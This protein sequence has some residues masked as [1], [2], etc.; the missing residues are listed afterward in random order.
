VRDGVNRL[1]VNL[2]GVS[3]LSVRIF[4]EQE[5][6]PTI[7]GGI[8]ELRIPGV[9]ATEALRPPVIAERALRG[10]RAALSYVFQRTTG[11]DPF[12]RDPWHG[13]SSSALVRDRGD[14]ETGLER[15]FS[16]PAART[17]R[18]DGWVTATARAPD[19]ALDAFVGLKGAF[20]SSARFEGRPGYRASSAFDGTDAPW[21]GSWQDGRS[22]WIEWVRPAT[23][24][25]LTLDPVPGVRQPTRVRLRSERGVSAAVDVVGGVAR[26]RQPVSGRRFRL[27]ILRSAFPAGTPGIDRRRRA[28]GIAEIRGP[29]VPSVRVPR[30]GALRPGC[31]ALAVEIGAVTVGMAV[32]GSIA[33]L[34]AGR[35]LRAHDCDTIGLPAGETRL[36]SVSG[37]FTPYVLRLRSGNSTPAPA[38]GR[39]V[40]AGTATRG[41]R[42]DVR[43]AL[44]GPARLVLAES[45]N[46]GRRASCDGKDLGVPEVGD[47]FGTAWRVPA[48]CRNVSITFAPNRLVNAGYAISLA[49]AALLLVLLVAGRRRLEVG[50]FG[51]VLANVADAPQGMPTRRALLI[52]VPAGLAFGFVFAARGVPLFALGVFLV[53]WR[54]IGA[55]P[56]ALAGGAVLGIA[57]P[58]LTAILRPENRGGYNPEYAIDGIAIHWV[59][60]AGVAL[61]V[62]ALS[63]AMGRPGRARSAPPTGDAPPP[64]A[65]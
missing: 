13:A 10:T 52:A 6:G 38:P 46:R 19:A 25:Q 14:G 3:S 28:V 37:T 50:R 4:V 54:G 24:R 49:V 33:D 58:I 61:F 16:P 31:T 48:S 51:V 2:R 65:A 9:E 15:R 17:W 20:N 27:E 42:E 5:P 39:V 64:P 7:T 59:T 63:R 53:L 41:G 57:V 40:S 8:R 60:V 47:A 11:D 45:Y 35:P 62:L 26:F 21:I 23:L 12:R 22:V 1:N 43:L 30:S 32:E 29:G 34:D 36:S 55:K 18:L 44:T 56:L